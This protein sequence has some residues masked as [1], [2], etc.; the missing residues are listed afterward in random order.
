MSTYRQ[1]ICALSLHRHK[2]STDPWVFFRFDVDLFPWHEGVN[3]LVDFIFSKCAVGSVEGARFVEK[4]TARV[5]IEVGSTVKD[6]GQ[7]QKD[8]NE[9][10]PDPRSI[11]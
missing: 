5:T 7:V 4:A 1:V 9:R 11:R 6:C 2:R 3:V 8:E 10:G